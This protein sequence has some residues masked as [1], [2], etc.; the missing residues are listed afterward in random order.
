MKCRINLTIES[1]N[2]IILFGKNGSIFVAL[3]FKLVE[4]EK[5]NF[6]QYVVRFVFFL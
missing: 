4:N 2:Y 1:G 3:T 6:Y 5:N